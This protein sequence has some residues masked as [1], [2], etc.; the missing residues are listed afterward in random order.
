MVREAELRRLAG[1]ELSSAPRSFARTNFD[2]E[3][4]LL[5]EAFVLRDQ[6]TCIW[7]LVE[8]VEPHGHLTFRL[9]K[10]AARQRGSRKTSR[11]AD[12]M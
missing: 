2:V 12:P 4:S 11:D 9:R 8:P 1:D 6:E 10:A 7:S 5:V 3:T